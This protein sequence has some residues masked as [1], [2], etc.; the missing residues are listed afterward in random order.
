MLKEEYLKMF[1][2]GLQWKED[3]Y[4]VMMAKGS[5]LVPCDDSK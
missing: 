5:H 1:T 2:G 3:F 4:I